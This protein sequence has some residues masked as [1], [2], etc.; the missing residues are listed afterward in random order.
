M[1]DLEKLLIKLIKIGVILIIFTPLVMGEFGLSFSEWPKTAF[2]RILTEIVFIFY[3]L[4]VWISSKYLPRLSLLVLAVS[5]FIGVLGLST[6]TSINPA[7]SF[8]GNLERGGGLATYLHFLIFFLILIGV[9]KEKKEW[10]FFLKVTVFVGL[11]SSVAGILQ[12]LGKYSFYGNSLP[13]RMSGTLSNPDFF[14]NYLV[15]SIFLGIFLVFVEKK[16]IWKLCFGGIVVLNCVNLLFTKTRGAWLGFLIGL[17]FFTFFWLF[18]Y[19]KPYPK[20]K[21]ITLYGLLFLALIVFVV[22]LNQDILHLNENIFFQRFLS[23]FDYSA[24]KPRLIGW[25]IAIKA[26]RENIVS[27]RGLETLSFFS[28][29]YFK[30]DYY[31]FLREGIIFDRS[32]NAFV[33]LLANAGLLGLL[34]YLFIFFT[35]LYLLFKKNKEFRETANLL[36]ITFF[37]SYFVQNF[38]S[39][40]TITTYL[41]FFLILGFVNNNYI[42]Y[43]PRENIIQRKLSFFNGRKGLKKALIVALIFLSLAGIYEINLKPALACRTFIEGLDLERGDFSG[44]LAKFKKA[45]SLKTIYDKEINMALTQHLI[46]VSEKGEKSGFNKKINEL[47]FSSKFSFEKEL[48]KPD[49]KYLFSHELVVRA[50]ERLY[51]TSKDKNILEAM[52]RISDKA[53]SFNNQSPIFWRLFGKVKI[54]QGQY[55]EGERM[56]K[57]SFEVGA[58]DMENQIIFYQ[59]LGA[60]YYEAGEKEKSAKNFERTVNLLILSRK[61]MNPSELYIRDISFIDNVALI[62]LFELESPEQA[63]QIYER[64]MENFPQYKDEMERRLRQLGL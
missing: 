54:L 58:K 50:D 46:D 33:D 7:R 55:E 56:F 17:A 39:F 26:W 25:E 6:L 63:R 4:L 36:I 38:F 42:F 57:K 28:D 35:A 52:E 18:K 2:F 14:G 9:F 53:L 64:I 5:V 23:T 49:I 60:A 32:H 31:K 47:L 43:V 59:N 41:I 61:F 11:L 10:L 21:K 22:F 13:D 29:K 40:D 12:K 44:A 48:G 16:L 30:S 27:G 34:G 51:L 24:L 1:D 19:S 3:L 37:V 15:L 45:I 20:L 62:Y 8:W